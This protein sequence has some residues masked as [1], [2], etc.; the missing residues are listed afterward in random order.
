[1]D[2]LDDIVSTYEYECGMVPSTR[3]G[4]KR[5]KRKKNK[6]RKAKK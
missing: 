3:A 4:G 1:M 2:K 5:V 6:T